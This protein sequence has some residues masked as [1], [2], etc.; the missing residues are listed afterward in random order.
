MHYL[1]NKKRKFWTVVF[2]FGAILVAAIIADYLFYYHRIYPGI[3]FAELPLGKQS[4]TEAAWQLKRYLQNL[5]FKEKAV[6]FTAGEEVIWKT[7]GELGIEPDIETMVNNAYNTARKGLFFLNYWQRFSLVREKYNLPLQIKVDYQKFRHTL[8]KAAA[9]LQQE[10]VN[11]KFVLVEDKKTVAIEPDIPGR[12]LDLAATYQKL[13]EISVS[14]ST[15]LACPIIFRPQAAEITAAKLET[16]QVKEE[17]SS[18]T[19]HILNDNPQRMQN[20]RLAAEAIDEMVLLPGEEF[21]FNG[22]VGDTTAEKGYQPAPVIVSGKITEGLGGGVCQV[23][24]TL[25]NAASLANLE[26]LERRNHGLY[27]DYVPPGLDATIAY[28][29]IDLRFKNSLPYAIWIKT[30]MEADKLT[31]S[32]YS[33]KIP[34]QEV[35]IYTTN[36]KKIPPPEEFI[37][38]D[39]LP[40]GERKLLSSGKAGYVTTV[41]RVISLHGREVKKERLSQDFYKPLPAQYLL[42]TGGAALK[43]ET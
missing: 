32:F 30:F 35:E 28:G 1:G 23:S 6:E 15:P 24:T 42:G 36:V 4:K 33:T 26:I 7:F 10:P 41:W 43:K 22:T 9:H 34:G 14:L 18:Y 13:Q 31:V 29:S 8:Q 3:V 38:T 40:R 20:I 16:L 27:V 21:S 19:T 2:L 25:Y 5:N 37:A 12:R 39:S 11:A 17:I